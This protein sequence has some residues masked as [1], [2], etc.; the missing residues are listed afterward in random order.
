MIRGKVKVGSE[1]I[2]DEGLKA[3]VKELLEDGSRVVKFF[4]Q[5]K[6]AQFAQLVEIFE[7]IGH[8]P[9]PLYMNREDSK[10]DEK[11]YQ[12]LF[13]KEA[14]SVAAPTASLHFTKELLVED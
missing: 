1:L 5:N 13:A 12:T 11:N 14:G 3:V 2:F 10:E 7:K 8:I 9:L 6:E 4:I